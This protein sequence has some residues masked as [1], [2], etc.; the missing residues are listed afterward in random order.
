[1]FQL[2]VNTMF[3]KH[4]LT[5]LTFTLVT[6]TTAVAVEPLTLLYTARTD[7]RLENCRCPRDP[8]GALEKRLPEI[9]RIRDMGPVILVDAGD[10]F[11][12]TLDS[13][14]AEAILEA[15]RLHHYDAVTLGEQELRY[16]SDWVHKID[17]QLPLV[18]A[19]L[20]YQGGGPVGETV[21]VF[22]RDGE[23]VAVTGIT[24][25]DAVRR[26]GPAFY[27]N[28]SLLDVNQALA[29]AFADIPDAA[30][31]VVLAHVPRQ[32]IEQNPDL[33]QG[34]DLLVSGHDADVIDGAEQV[35]ETFMVQPGAKGRFLGVARFHGPRVRAEARSIAPSLPDDPRIVQIVMDLKRKRKP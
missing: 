22:E 14:G 19:N 35:G 25:P 3:T 24:H 18:S 23:T 32:T 1:M 20:S 8:N 5:L 33:W 27:E 12:P 31:K 15:Y 28:F 6:A 17:S 16:G 13:L 11:P 4:I 10:F 21:R 7:G 9:Q 29:Q 34:V 30:R 2:C 26:L